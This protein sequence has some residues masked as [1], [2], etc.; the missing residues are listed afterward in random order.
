MTENEFV[1]RQRL[2]NS[3]DAEA[4]YELYLRKEQE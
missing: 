3:G 4:Q 2:A 1:E